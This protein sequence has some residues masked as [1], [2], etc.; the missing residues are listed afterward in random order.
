MYNK[1]DTTPLVVDLDGTLIKTDLLLEAMILLL[2][3]NPVYILRSLSWLFKGKAYLKN[4]IFGLVQIQYRLLPYNHQVL[5]FLQEEY[6]AGRKIVLATATPLS[7]AIEIAKLHPV[8]NEVYGT[9]ATV[10][11]K[12]INKLNLLQDKFGKA[13]FDYIG[14]SKADFPI[15]ASCRNAYLVNPSWLTVATVKKSTLKTIWASEKASL[16]DYFKA[17]RIYQ[18]IKNLLLF[19]PLLTSHS[20]KQIDLLKANCFAFLAFGMV[21]S[22]GYLLND[23]LDINSDRKHPRKKFRPVASGKLLLHNVVILAF[24][25]LAGGLILAASINLLFLFILLLYFFISFT[26]SLFFKKIVL[27]D[28]FILAM[29]YSIRVFAGGVV[30]NIELSFWLIAFSTFLF[31]SLAFVKRYSELIQIEDETD[32]KN[33]GRGYRVEDLG[34]LQIMGIVSGFLAIVV[35]SLYIN[36][37]EVTVLYSKPRILWGISFLFLFWISHIWLITTRGKMTDDPILFAIKDITSYFIFLFTVI[38]LF[39]SV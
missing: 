15:F 24:A 33:Q 9:D 20:L 23:L 10:N 32:L 6:N 11:L 26:Y 34:L 16:K 27:Y 37:S 7:S 8:F 38:L 25:L 30:V 1:D 35:F 18:W 29:L 39:I 19:V 28:V 13:K 3:K 36:S 5:D 14:D 22:A 21:A 31:L 17:I 2:K 4:K 12:G